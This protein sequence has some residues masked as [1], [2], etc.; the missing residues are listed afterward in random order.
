M[1]ALMASGNSV[2]SRG[3]MASQ[4][5]G[6]FAASN[7]QPG[8]SIAKF[9]STNSSQPRRRL[10]TGRPARRGIAKYKN[11]MNALPSHPKRM[12]WV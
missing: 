11:A 1:T 6:M 4:G 7:A 10:V 8:M 9:Q 12:P 3:L 2:H 5:C